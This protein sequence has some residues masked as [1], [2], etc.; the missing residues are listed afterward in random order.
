MFLETG[1]CGSCWADQWALERRELFCQG[2]TPTILRDAHYQFSTKIL[3]PKIL[4]S[5][6]RKFIGQFDK[7]F[8][9]E[10]SWLGI[11]ITGRQ[12]YSTFLYN[13]PTGTSIQCVLRFLQQGLT[14]RSSHRVRELSLKT[15]IW[16]SW[17]CGCY[18]QFSPANPG[19]SLRGNHT[20]N[21]LDPT[22]S[23]PSR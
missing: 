6:P 11:H 22:L 5:I 20:T 12:V 8:G 1:E 3:H 2:N 13:T 9:K 14:S 15:D 17:S 21:S 10:G 7:S 4:G 19:N 23:I 18:Y 16:V